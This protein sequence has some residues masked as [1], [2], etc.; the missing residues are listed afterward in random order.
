M[1]HESEIARIRQQIEDE[2]QAMQQALS[3]LSMSASHEMIQYRYTAIGQYRDQLVPLVG[4]EQASHLMTEAYTRGVEAQ[5][6]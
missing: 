1:S 5:N 3:G 2:S 6:G 4:D